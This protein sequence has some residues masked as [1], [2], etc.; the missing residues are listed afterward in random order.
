MCDKFYKKLPS[1]ALDA[2]EFLRL[3]GLDKEFEFDNPD[4]VQFAVAE[5]SLK[6]MLDA[7]KRD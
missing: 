2:Q 3:A 1:D 5:M 4:I 7:M 6:K